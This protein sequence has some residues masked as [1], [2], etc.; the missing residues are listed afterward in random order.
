MG[1]SAASLFLELLKRVP[2]QP[3]HQQESSLPSVTYT[4]PVFPAENNNSSSRSDDEPVL[5]WMPYQNNALTSLVLYGVLAVL[6]TTLNIFQISSLFIQENL[7]RKGNVLLANLAMANLLVSSVGFPVTVVAILAGSQGSLL[8]CRWQ[9]YPALLGF[10]TT[11]FT[12]LF[13]AAENY[14][15]SC[16]QD[17][18]V[19]SSVCGAKLVIFLVLATWTIA[20][21]LVLV[22]TLVTGG[23][24][25]CE[26]DMRESKMFV[27]LCVPFALTVAVFAKA[28]HEQRDYSYNLEL[29]NCLATREEILQR[30]LLRSNA[31]AYTLFLLL[32]LPFLLTVI[33]SPSLRGGSAVETLF[34]TAQ[35]FSCICGCVYAF[36]HDAFRQGFLYLVHYFCCK[37]HPEFS[38]PPIGDEKATSS[39]RV[40]VG[41]DSRVGERRHRYG[42]AATMG[43]LSF[44]ATDTCRTRVEE[45]FL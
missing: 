25:V 11:V 30:N 16:R 10:Y 27:A 1:A 45:D 7:R 36:T 34:F 20:G 12:F 29:R 14:V 3:S 42:R 13:I 22:V 28:V 19:Y 38:K 32:W 5:Q 24:D 17:R 39:I 21:A 41:M 43:L 35:C 9:W 33:I 6:G 40:H 31:I 26:R 44:A 8:T 18:D 15:R 37:S 2:Q 4:G 23:L